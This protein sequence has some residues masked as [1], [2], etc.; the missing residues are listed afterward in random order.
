MTRAPHSA[1]YTAVQIQHKINNQ[2]G[3]STALYKHCNEEL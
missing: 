3:N 1:P 2:K